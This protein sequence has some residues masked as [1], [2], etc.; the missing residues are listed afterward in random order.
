[1]RV[2]HLLRF[3]LVLVPLLAGP[4]DAED[5]AVAPED[6][7]AIRA[8]IEGQIEAFRRDDGAAAFSYAAPVIRERF[9]TPDNF[10]EMVRTGYRPVYRPREIA[11]GALEMRDGRLVQRVLLVGPDGVATAALYVMERQP[12][13]SWKIAAC[14]L[15]TPDDKAT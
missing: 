2:G 14:I 11:F 8:V 9:A 5:A 12:D 6:R 13:G 4:A 1:M 10:M 3:L 15:T 7:A